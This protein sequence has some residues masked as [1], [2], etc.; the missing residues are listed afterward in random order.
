MAKLRINLAHQEIIMSKII[1]VIIDGTEF[2]KSEFTIKH[3]NRK[4]NSINTRTIQ[5]FYNFIKRNEKSINFITFKIHSLEQLFCLHLKNG[6]KH[7]LDG[8][9]FYQEYKNYTFIGCSY[10]IN[11]EKLE[12]HD[13]KRKTR[14]I[15]LKTL[16]NVI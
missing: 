8:P 9:A 10:F 7:N 14:A 6:K 1:S 15:K 12:Y 16:N 4:C 5:E 2:K 11:G 13:W 3:E